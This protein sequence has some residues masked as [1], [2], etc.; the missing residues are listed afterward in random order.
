MTTLFYLL[1]AMADAVIVVGAIA[2]ILGTIGAVL[3]A[4]WKT[5]FAPR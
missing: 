4:V 1:E 5:S 3:Y 2:F